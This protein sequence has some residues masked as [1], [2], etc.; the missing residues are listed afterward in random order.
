MS[1]AMEN[2]NKQIRICVLGAGAGG[3]CAGRH[4][5]NDERFMVDIYEQTGAIGGTWVYTDQIGTDEYGLPIHSSM[6]KN[7]R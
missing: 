2:N 7:L 3:L 4:F 1:V 6:Y 5:C